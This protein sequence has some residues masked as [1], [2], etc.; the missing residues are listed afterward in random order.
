MAGSS[1]AIEFIE[2]V[3]PQFDLLVADARVL[4]PDRAGGRLERA[5]I[6]INDGRIV[7]LAPP[8][9]V[10]RDAASER[11]AAGGGLAMP[12]LV[13][14]HTHSPENLARG[15]AERARL[16]EWMG[17]VWPDLDSLSPDTV[18]LAIEV[19]AAE[20]IRHG[21]TS[22]VDHFRQTPMSAPVLASAVEAYAAIG[23]R[24]TLAVML[25]DPAGAGGLIGAPHVSAAPSAADQISLLA[26]TSLWARQKG[27]VLAFGPSAPHRCSDALLR[28]IAREQRYLPV[29]THVDETVE[30]AQ[31]AYRRFGRTTVSQLDQVGLLGPRL[32]CAHAVHVTAPD[33]DRLA[34]TGT[35]VV[36]NPVSNMRLGSGIAPLTAFLAAGVAVALGTDGA[37]SNDTQNPWEA[38]KLATM[39]PRVG[40]ADPADWPSAATMLALATRVGHRVTGLAATEPGAGTIADG[41][42]A[43]LIV[44]DDDPLAQLDELR[45]E[46]NLVL[47]SPSHRPCH[48]IARGRV[49]MRDRSL[50][51]IDEAALRDRLR[52]HR[53]EL[54]A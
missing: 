54:A 24:C 28:M 19:G 13:N 53:R 33:I 31:A 22:I 49:L 18:R 40:T 42:P 4:N 43:D 12:G 14:A 41:A 30:E 45:P 26:E 8:T 27:V 16:P 36:H 1:G 6:L 20:M 44:F 10:P 51:T 15:R 3:P 29:H 2:P 25:R 34:A 52:A 46:A 48:V 21:V 38:I 9:S 37:A 23:I 35:V 39:L 7:R 50:T 17:A 47:G 5:D 32:A 11:I